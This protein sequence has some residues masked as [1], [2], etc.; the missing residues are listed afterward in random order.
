[1]DLQQ[2][3]GEAYNREEDEHEDE[4]E[5]EY[6]SEDDRDTVAWEDDQLLLHDDIT[7]VLSEEEDE[8]EED[9]F[10][11]YNP[12]FEATDYNSRYKKS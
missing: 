4:H 7:P 1:M 9:R 12:F 6:D 8:E 11:D 3:V 10:S 2:P 5:D